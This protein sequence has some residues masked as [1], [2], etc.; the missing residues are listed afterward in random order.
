MKIIFL[1][2]DASRT[3]IQLQKQDQS[4]PNWTRYMIF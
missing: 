2:N 4:I 3:T 1:L